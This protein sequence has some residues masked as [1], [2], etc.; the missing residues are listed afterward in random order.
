M[1]I[2]LDGSG[3][4][5]EKLVKIARHN[6]PVE[7]DPQALKRMEKC[8]AML[9]RKIDAREIMYGVNTGIGEFSEYFVHKQTLTSAWFSSHHK[10]I[11]W[12]GHYCIPY[13]GRDSTLNGHLFCP[14]SCALSKHSF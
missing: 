11:A 5:I 10:N 3:L 4:T 6:E 13:T 9:E 14:L 7:L 8:R 12:C 1:A 2:V